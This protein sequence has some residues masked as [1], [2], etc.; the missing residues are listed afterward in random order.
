MLILEVIPALHYIAIDKT[1]Q[2]YPLID[3]SA[4]AELHTMIL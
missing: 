4:N 3:I 2:I 1:E